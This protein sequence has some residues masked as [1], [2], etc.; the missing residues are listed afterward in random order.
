MAKGLW[1]SVCKTEIIMNRNYSKELE[2]IL[3]LNE[4]K[5]KKLFLHSCCAPCSS[6]V[7]EYLR[8]FFRITVFYYNPNISEE[9]EYQKRV[10]EQ[11]RLI[12]EYNK[13]TEEGYPI[14]VIE[15]DY[16]KA[17]FFQSVKGLERCKEGGRKMLCLL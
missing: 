3:A 8:P 16:D 14:E 13:K 9:E 7:L 5:G 10:Q 1:S 17:L 15:G 2:Q 11:K 4:N 12:R 6:Y